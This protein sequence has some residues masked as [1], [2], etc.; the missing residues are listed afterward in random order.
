MSGKTWLQKLDEIQDGWKNVIWKNE[1]VEMVAKER[2]T[3]CAKCDDNVS[4]VCK[5]CGCPLF[6]KTRSMKETNK[7]DLKKWKR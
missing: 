5:N 7:C 1:E 2:A 4:N 6:A 3:V